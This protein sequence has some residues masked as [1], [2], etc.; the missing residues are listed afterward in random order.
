MK[1]ITLSSK[2]RSLHCL[3][4][5]CNWVIS[6]LSSTPI[7]STTVELILNGSLAFE[8][9]SFNENSISVGEET[10]ATLEC[11]DT[12]ILTINSFEVN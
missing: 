8:D 2:K 1:G 9:L 4:G 12:T 6:A 7:L 11:V 10:L 5:K 3:I